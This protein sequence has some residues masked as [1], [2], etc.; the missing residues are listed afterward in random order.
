VAMEREIVVEDKL[1]LKGLSQ[2]CSSPERRARV[3]GSANP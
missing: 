2:K 1:D 3:G